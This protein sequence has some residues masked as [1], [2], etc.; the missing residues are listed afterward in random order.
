MSLDFIWFAIVLKIPLLLLVLAV[1]WAIRQEPEDPASHDDDGGIRRSDD[2]HPPL[3]PFPRRPRRGP[4]GDP[5]PRSPA[6]VRT[7]RARVRTL[8]H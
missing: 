8:G 5:P 3:R 1:W 7:A 6:R 4:H 2:R